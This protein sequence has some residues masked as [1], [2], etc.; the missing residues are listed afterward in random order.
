M[1]KLRRTVGIGLLAVGLLVGATGC[2]SAN[3][4]PG[5]GATSPSGPSGYVYFLNNAPELANQYA[6]IAAEYNKE[7]GEDIQIVTP[8]AGTYD[9]TLTTE[10]GS[11]KPPTI[12]QIDG[13]LGYAQRKDN[14]A[15]LTE[16]EIYMNL[17]DQNLVVSSGNGVYGVPDNLRGYGIYYNDAIM[18]KYFALPDKNVPITSADQI[19]S[20]DL[21]QQVVQD[22][23]AHKS[24]LGIQGVFSSTSLAPGED[25]RWQTYMVN[26]PLFYEFQQNNVDLT[27]GTPDT[28]DFTYGDNMKSLF[29]L[30]LN[31]ST[32]APADLGSKTEQ[33]SIDE[34]ALGQS[35]MVQSGNWSWLQISGIQG[36]TVQTSDLHML[37]LYM[38][39]PGEGTYGIPIGSEDFLSVN[40]KADPAAQQASLD[41]LAWLFS[42]D[43]GKSAVSTDL[44]FI[45]PFVSFAVGQSPT[46]PISTE[47]MNWMKADTYLVPWTAMKVIPDQAWSTDFGADLLAYAQGSE[48][49]PTVETSMVQDWATQAAAPK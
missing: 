21:L 13:P 14:C 10:L 8:P 24:Q 2:G 15:D 27:K 1:T 11:S 19:T 9:D 25:S 5:I 31:N 22:M 39:I 33:D 34:F 48:D 46:D 29:D 40:A 36:N 30:Y 32:T 16:S 42:S 37:P 17:T 7:T 23:T 4:T 43:Y 12:F 49:W 45:A 28:I 35:A 41:F 38:G 20:F 6:S 47:L 26:V 18:Q 44:G 3:N